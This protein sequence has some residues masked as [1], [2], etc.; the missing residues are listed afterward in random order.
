M[1]DAEIEAL[2]SMIDGH[3]FVRLPDRPSTPAR[4][5]IAIGSKVENHWRSVRRG[6]RSSAGNAR[7]RSPLV[8]SRRSE[9]RR[10]MDRA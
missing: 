10:P 8:S 1:P 7:S 4:R 6:V 3:G 2:K 5:K 9:G